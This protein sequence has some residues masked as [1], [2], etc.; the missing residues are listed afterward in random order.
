MKI[1]NV[2]E[3]MLIVTKK[4]TSAKDNPDLK[5]FKL[6]VMTE[7]DELGEVSCGKEIFEL[8]EKGKEYSFSVVFDTQYKSYK[9]VGLVGK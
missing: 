4:I 5:Y 6:G 7:D 8:V 1:K 3:K 2:T 9:I